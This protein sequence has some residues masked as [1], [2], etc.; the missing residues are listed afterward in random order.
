MTRR[1]RVLIGA[2]ALI[3]LVLIATMLASRYRRRAEVQAW[4]RVALDA[5]ALAQLE[6]LD[7]PSLLPETKAEGQVY[8]LDTLWMRGDGAERRVVRPVLV[9][10]MPDAYSGIQMD[11]RLALHLLNYGPGGATLEATPLA[12]RDLQISVALGEQTSFFAP[13]SLRLMRRHALAE[14]SVIPLPEIAWIGDSSMDRTRTAQAFLDASEWRQGDVPA[15][16]CRGLR[17]RAGEATGDTAQLDVRYHAL[18]DSTVGDAQQALV[19]ID[20]AVVT[21]QGEALPERFQATLTIPYR[22][23]APRD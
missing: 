3:L 6:L 16:D 22:I 8:A 5:E 17:Y 11:A 15:Q 18:L 20:G 14:T 1:T 4:R 10:T 23:A 13:S 12:W 19:Q 2:L 21:A 9:A 7:E